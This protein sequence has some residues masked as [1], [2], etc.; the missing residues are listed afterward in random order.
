MKIGVILLL[1]GL[2]SSVFSEGIGV[3]ESKGLFLKDKIYINAI[4][5]PDIKGIT[6]YWTYYS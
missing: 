2:I 5:D 6:C 4:D 1:I 3:V